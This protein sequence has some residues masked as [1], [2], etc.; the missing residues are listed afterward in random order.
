MT[1]MTNGRLSSRTKN[2][3]TVVLVL[4]LG[5]VAGMT[6]LAVD[7]A[8]GG[9]ISRAAAQEE[10]TATETATEPTDDGTSDALAALPPITFEV[11]LSRD[12][13]EP[14][15]VEPTANAAGPAGTPAVP[16]V[17]PS[18][19]PSPGATPG[20]SPSGTPN[21][22]ASPT[23]GTGT[24]TEGCSQGSSTVCNG[25]TISLVDIQTNAAGQSIALV[26]VNGQVYEVSVG[27]TFAGNFRLDAI[28]GNCASL[29]FG[30]ESF[31]LCEGEQVLK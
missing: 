9:V 8:D 4:V 26:Q 6:T 3:L 27:Q 16:G 1:T 14:V 7:P 17:D 22:T 2:V 30:D 19:S 21:P 20:P 12:P 18:A 13:F 5:V 29:L 15:F 31:T 11:F 23:P 28:A 24:P 10:P 25:Q